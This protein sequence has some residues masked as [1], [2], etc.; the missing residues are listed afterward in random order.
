MCARLLTLTTAA[1]AT[2]AV[3]AT[4]ACSDP[5]EP[6]PPDV[7]TGAYHG[8]LQRGWLLPPDSAGA[9][10]LGEDLDGDGTI[11]N[12]GG[13]LV[14]AL[15]GL[16][17]EL[18]EASADAFA[19][20]QLVALH[21]LRADHLD[22]DASIEWRTYDG[23][24]GAPPRFDGTDRPVAAVETGR[25]AGMIRGGHAELAWGQTAV[26]LP[27]FPDQSPLRLPLLDARITVD[28]DA[29]G[30][31]GRVAGG[32]PSDE[33]EGA[34]LP[35]L[36]VELIVHLARHPDHEFTPI[37]MRVFDT[38]HDGKLTVAEVLA[39]ELMQGAFRP[40]L[41]LDGDGEP[42]ALSFGLGFDCVAA[43]FAPPEP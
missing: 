41:D 39:T 3:A 35:L 4:A 19:S 34:I 40:D 28:V 15:I 14:G 26:S 30:C 42:D 27:F 12:A 17:L 18:E 2:A 38:D 43:T 36:A 5:D 11:D 9:R 13:Q 23:V 32:V 8:F 6:A 25:L 29:A 37:A 31:T 1:V 33:L 10:D 16:G 7:T 21:R 22:A 20:G 24:P